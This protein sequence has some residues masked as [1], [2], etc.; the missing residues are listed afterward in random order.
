MTIVIANAAGFWG[1]DV[2]APRRLVELAEVDYLTLEYLAELTLSIMARQ[3]QKDASHGYASDF[4]AVVESLGPLLIDQ[5][6][7]RIVTNAGGLNPQQCAIAV[8]NVLDRFGMGETQ[9]GVVSGDDLYDRIDELRAAGCT[10]DHFDTGQSFD[11][12]RASLISANAYLGA[13]P[14]T[15]ALD[16][17][18][19]IVITGRVAEVSL[20]VGPVMHEFDWQWDDWNRL[21]AATVAGH[22]IECGAQST[23]GYSTRWQEY[24]LADVGYPIAE[25]DGDG[26]VVITKPAGTGGRVSRLTVAEQLVY[27]IGNPAHYLTP[28]VDVDFTSLA[29]SQVGDDRVAI[30]EAVGSPPP[31]DYKVSM[32]YACGFT[33]AG[34]LLVFG[35]DC[36][37][38]SRA[39]VRLI[40]ERLHAAGI[41][42]D[43]VH[44][45][46][47]GHG[48]ATGTSPPRDLKEIVLRIAARDQRREAVEMF[49]KQFAPLI[50][51]GPAGLAGYAQ[52]RPAVRPVFSYWPALVPKDALEPQV[53]VRTAKQWRQ[54]S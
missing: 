41:E 4:V 18:A 33:A 8:A 24:D 26:E 6:R 30:D 21:A 12:V 46:L 3:R 23:G 42:L 34:E 29:V 17:G 22:V 16:R 36:V 48:E 25:I 43:Q 38:K 54:S 49:T 40:V 14:I 15:A 10:F 51:S 2:A 52:G 37:D 5:P 44:S 35:D 45:E 27:E 1:D 20:T 53:E 28:D 9:I 13:K 47:L 11:D 39:C 31:D 32:A 50:T 7:L 19:R